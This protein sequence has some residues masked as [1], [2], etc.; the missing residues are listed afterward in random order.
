M[1]I[2]KAMEADVEIKIKELRVDGGATVNNSLMQFQAGVLNTKAI[3]PK[4]VENTAMGAAFLAGLAVGFWKNEEEI[5]KIWQ[6][7]QEFEPTKERENRCKNKILVQSCRSF[8][9]FD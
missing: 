8:R 9:V 7:D 5:K 3:R 6:I 2:L 4:V 1:D